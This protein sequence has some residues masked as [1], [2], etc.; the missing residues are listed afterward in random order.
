MCA[1]LFFSVYVYRVGN[2][3]KK[4]KQEYQNYWLKR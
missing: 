4:V 2:G 1:L 3:L